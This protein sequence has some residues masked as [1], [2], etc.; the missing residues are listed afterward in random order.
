[1][2]VNSGFSLT[3]FL[4]GIE[5]AKYVYMFV[6]IKK[7]NTGLIKFPT[8][9]NVFLVGVNFSISQYQTVT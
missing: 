8:F 3:F 1:M 2:N 4:G 9:V 5:I 6:L 7:K